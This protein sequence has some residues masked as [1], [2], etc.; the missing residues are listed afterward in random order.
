MKVT[1]NHQGKDVEMLTVSAIIV[2]NAI[3]NQDFLVSK[4]QSWAEPFFGNLKARIDNAFNQILGIDSA[5]KM[6]EATQVVLKIQEKSINDLTELKI[7]IKEDFKSDKTRRDEILRQLGYTAYYKM[8]QKRDQEALTQLLYQFKKSLTDT[9]QEEIT[10]KG[11]SPEILN[12]ICTY[13]EQLSQANIAQETHKGTK[14]TINR[15]IVAEIVEIY[16]EV[17]SVAKI[18]RNF[19]KGNPAKQDLFSYSKIFKKLNA[20]TRTAEEE[21]QAE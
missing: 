11:I 17:I 2:E 3:A 8:V 15:E 20:S 19:Y 12:R 4:R 13:A 10:Q 5:S 18:A 21:I 16:S 9:L 7:Q 1:R 6:R 14:K